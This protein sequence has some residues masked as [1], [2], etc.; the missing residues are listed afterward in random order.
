MNINSQSLK[1][2]TV[3]Y[4]NTAYEG[5]IPD[6]IIEKIGCRSFGFLYPY[7]C[8]S[9]PSEG[10]CSY[11]DSLVGLFPS[12]AVHCDTLYFYNSVYEIQTENLVSIYPS[13]ADEYLF[14][15]K[16]QRSNSASVEIYNYTG[17]LVFENKNFKEENIDTQNL[18]NGFHVLKYTEGKNYSAIKFWC[19]TESH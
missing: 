3:N 17:Q 19:S 4:V 5:M 6:T 7:I 11:E 16:S 2:M 1:W 9:D 14:I 13:P 8:S 10:F 12:T 18:Q 15:Q